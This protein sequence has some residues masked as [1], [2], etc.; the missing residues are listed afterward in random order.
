MD[1]CVWENKAGL[2]VE[3]VWFLG[4]HMSQC[5]LTLDCFPL[6]SKPYFFLSTLVVQHKEQNEKARS[7]LQQAYMGMITLRASLCYLSRN[8]NMQV[9]RGYITSTF[10]G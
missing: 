9:S 5:F 8:R 4:K 6:N 7:F 1:A 2:F 3:T 10:D